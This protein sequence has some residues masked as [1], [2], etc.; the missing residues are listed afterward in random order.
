MTRYYKEMLSDVCCLIL[1]IVVSG[2]VKEDWS[3]DSFRH[4]EEEKSVR[5]CCGN[6]LDTAL[7]K[8]TEGLESRGEGMKYSSVSQPPT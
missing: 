6:C 7:R 1:L 5:S 4:T 2:T 8:L 3:G